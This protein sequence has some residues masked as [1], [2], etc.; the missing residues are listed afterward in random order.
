[1]TVT[2]KQRA[3]TEEFVQVLQQVL[4]LLRE[5]KHAINEPA[6]DHDHL[7]QIIELVRAHNS[8]QGRTRRPPQPPGQDGKADEVPANPGPK[9]NKPVL[10]APSPVRLSKCQSEIVAVIRE[11]GR[12][13][14]TDEVLAY[15]TRIRPN[16]ST[17]VTKQYLAD[18][19]RFGILSNR[20]DV[21]P[22]G[23]GLREWD[24]T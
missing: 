10:G 20:K 22:R 6:S 9:P 14:T 23:Y 5:M 12:R 15:L 1:M 8:G 19:V 17:G 21:T 3:V 18:L 4:Q 13:L 24:E 7:D 16:P 11:A 2:T